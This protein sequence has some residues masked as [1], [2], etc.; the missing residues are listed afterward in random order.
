M[1]EEVKKAEEEAKVEEQK[2]EEAPAAAP[3]AE[4]EDAAAGQGEEEKK[5]EEEAAAK[6]RRPPPPPAPPVI[7]G[8]DLHCTGCANKIKRCILRCKGVE[9]VEVDMAQNQVTVKGIV[10]PQGIC[11]GLRKR[12]M[13]NATV[14]SPPPPPPPAPTEAD[15]AA[16]VP[17][18]EPVVVRSQVSE[19]TTVELLVNMH[20]EACALQLQKKILKMRGVQSAGANSSAG[21]LTV[22]GTMSADKLVQYIHR[23]T[24]KLATVLP[25]PQPP[26][27]PKEEEI[28][29]EGGDNKPEEPPA[30]DA[31]ANKEDQKKLPAED[32]AEKKDAE[33]E[34]KE[35]EGAKPENGG[36]EKKEGDEEKVKPPELLAVDGFP[37]EQMMKRMMYWPYPHKHYY[38]P[39]VDEEAVMARRMAMA[40]HPYTVPMMQW[41]P[42]SPP[43]PPL[44]PPVASPPMYQG[45]YYGNYDMMERP[46]P[47]APQ[48]FSDENPNACAIS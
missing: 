13:R 48:Y 32:A 21:K 42:P 1:G 22:T 19:V 20:C 17:K 27:A 43:P 28:K 14:I 26:E 3:E 4:K 40:V 38:N 44:A 5:K 7:L 15:S 9:G 34:K 35:E 16:A 12:T 11:E 8:I 31:N 36:A 25:P 29:K 10:D 46:P 24:G 41:T 45:Y 39:Q 18:E 2:K 33:G 23:R 6:E 47:A 30:E 37:P